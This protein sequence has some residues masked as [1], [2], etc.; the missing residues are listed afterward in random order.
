MSKKN[1]KI[2]VEGQGELALFTQILEQRYKVVLEAEETENKQHF[3]AEINT[4]DYSIELAVY[5]KELKSGGIDSTK[6]E[7]LMKHI[8]N[9][10]KIGYN[11]FVFIDA[12]TPQHRPAGGAAARKEYMKGL[13]EKYELKNT[14]FF[15]VPDNEKDGNLEDV[16]QHCIAERGKPFFSCLSSYTDCIKN[17]EKEN[18]PKEVEGQDLDKKKYEWYVYM[19]LG[20]REGGKKSASPNRKYISDDIWD[21]D[22]LNDS[23]LVN[24]L[25]REVFYFLDKKT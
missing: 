11:C 2:F 14:G 23:P 3:S 10:E 12:D 16:M 9:L 4:E 19:M 24:Y 6:I 8:K 17:L 20:H 7:S 18:F 21:L 15:I 5:N 25:D 1:V 22:G 13:L